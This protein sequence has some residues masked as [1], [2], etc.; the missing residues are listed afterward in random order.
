M[1]VCQWDVSQIV[2]IPAL[3]TIEILRTDMNTV[4][5]SYTGKK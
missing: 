5:G 1:D 4:V 2:Y 3:K